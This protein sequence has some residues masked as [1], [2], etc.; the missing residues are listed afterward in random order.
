MSELPRFTLSGDVTSVT[1]GR[2]DRTDRT[3]VLM[4]VCPR[5]R[6]R[7]RSLHVPSIGFKAL[8]IMLSTSSTAK[9]IRQW[10]LITLLV[11]FVVAVALYWPRNLLG[12]DKTTKPPVHALMGSQ[13]R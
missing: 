11:C 2:P 12:R 4:D 5:A 3:N 13:G 8:L 6:A 1:D 10:F 9:T 7:G